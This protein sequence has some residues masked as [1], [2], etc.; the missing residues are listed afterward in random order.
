MELL[1]WGELAL[2]IVTAVAG[3]KWWS[4]RARRRSA[5]AEAS[6]SESQAAALRFRTVD[7][8]ATH[9]TL[10]LGEM[11]ARLSDLAEADLER[12]EEIAELRSTLRSVEAALQVE[13]AKTEQLTKE[14]NHERRIVAALEAYLVALQEEGQF[15]ETA[16][17]AQLRASVEAARAG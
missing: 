12:Q 6:E 10:R 16:R 2:G 13:K 15:A 14:L 11:A 1:K 8:I 5:E 3:W 9:F 17:L 4:V 7:E